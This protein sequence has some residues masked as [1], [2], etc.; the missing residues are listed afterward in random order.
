MLSKARP[1]RRVSGQGCK[2]TY[3]ARRGDFVDHV[4]VVIRHIEI[5]ARVEGQTLRVWIRLAKSQRL[6]TCRRE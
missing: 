5:A 1:K 3:R 2:E 6:L 4:V